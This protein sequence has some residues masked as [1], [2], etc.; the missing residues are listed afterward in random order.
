MPGF[1][2]PKDAAD[3]NQILNNNKYVVIDFTATWCGPCRMITPI[4]EQLSTK[5]ENVVFVKV[6]VDELSVSYSVCVYEPWM[7]NPLFLF[8]ILLKNTLFVLCL[9]FTSW[10]MA[11]RLMILLVLTLPLLQPNFKTSLLKF[12]VYQIKNKSFFYPLLFSVYR[13]WL[14]S[15]HVHGYFSIL[16]YSIF[17]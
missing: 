16:I 6:D 13:V 14:C 12:I 17:H 3:L 4:L 2:V 10:G 15:F 1:T 9:P 8:R 7:I 11:K 5:F